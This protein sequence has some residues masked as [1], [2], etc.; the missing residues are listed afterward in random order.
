M[1]TNTVDA[2]CHII[3]WIV[4]KWIDLIS[5]IRDRILKMFNINNMKNAVMVAFILVTGLM[6]GTENVRISRRKKAAPATHAGAISI[7]TPDTLMKLSINV[8]V[9]KIE[10]IAVIV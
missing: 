7:V 4:W 6:S 3:Q 5:G 10:R 9:V 8:G 2:R 1:K